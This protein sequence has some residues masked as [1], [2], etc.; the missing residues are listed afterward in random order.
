MAPCLKASFLHSAMPPA[1]KEQV[2]AQLREGSI[3]F[4]LVSP[5]SLVEGNSIVHQLP[6]VAF[7]CIDEAHCLSEWSHNFRPS[8]LQLYKASMKFAIPT[9]LYFVS[10]SLLLHFSYKTLKHI[11]FC[12]AAILGD[13]I[14]QHLQSAFT[15]LNH[16][17]KKDGRLS[18]NRAINAYLAVPRMW[19]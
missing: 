10:D 18:F 14:Q 15:N 9:G 11:T 13:H 7:A 17:I 3:H 2:L 16:P 5:E 8:Y 1:Q 6:P 12:I 4:L 19:F